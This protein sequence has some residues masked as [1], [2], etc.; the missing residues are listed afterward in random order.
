MLQ[1]VKNMHKCITFNKN[2]GAGVTNFLVD[3]YIFITD[4]LGQQAGASSYL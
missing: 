3:E 1:I 2:F 4:L